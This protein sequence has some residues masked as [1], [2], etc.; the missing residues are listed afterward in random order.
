MVPCISQWYFGKG[1]R[2][3]RGLTAEKINKAI[4]GDWLDRGG[5]QSQSAGSLREA[6]IAHFEKNNATIFAVPEVVD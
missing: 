5:R 3:R 6:A 4:C 2:A 1:Q